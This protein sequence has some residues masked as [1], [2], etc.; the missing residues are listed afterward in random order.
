MGCALSILFGDRS[1]PKH[2]F[3]SAPAF[4]TLKQPAHAEKTSLRT[5]LNLHCPSLFS[6]FRPAWWLFN[7]HLQAVYSVIGDF[8]TVDKV[9]YDRTLL[10][11]KD[12]GTLGL[13]FTP[14]IS[15]RVV[16]D[17]A[18]IVV[19]LHGLSGG[20]HESYVRAIIAPAVTPVDQ[21]GLGYRAVVINSRGCAG[22]PLTTPQLYSSCHTDD[23]RQALL[24]ISQRYPEAP[25]LGLGFSLGANILT[26]YVAEEGEG[27]RLISACTL[28][29]PWDLAA[30][31]SHV[32][33]SWLHRN[34]Y[35]YTMT[36]NLK[37]LI[38]QHADSITKFPESRLAQSL[39]ELFS[40]KSLTISQFDN[41]ITIHAGGSPPHFP[42]AS[43]GDYYAYAASHK[44]L[45]DIRIPFLALNSDDDPIAKHIP[46]GET[47]NGWVTLIVTR[48]G[49]HMGWF[50][51]SEKGL[52]RWNTQ[53]VLE[54]FRTTAEILEIPQ[55]PVRQIYLA[56][57]WLVESGREQLGCQDI[58][59]G[60]IIEGAEGQEGMLPGL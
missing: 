29:C 12:G 18:P 35:A 46:I 52:K 2:F 45:G 34:V 43:A 13:D 36:N 23:L 3:P 55:K 30:N 25:L 28:A 57:G 19:V 21:G 31:S 5:L 40:R 1:G 44:V 58:G 14:P 41:L 17:E 39:P 50:E 27:C 60:G 51:S 6:P 15:E 22:V 9:V 38:S 32:D 11:V 26:R 54:W 53:P 10:R 8:S 7:G 4:V 47:D 33:N 49:G 37:C 24:H 59:G 42:F 56:D 20:S 16:P 48:G